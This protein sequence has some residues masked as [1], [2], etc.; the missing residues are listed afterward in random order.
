[1]QMGFSEQQARQ[2]LAQ[3]NGDFQAAIN[4]LLG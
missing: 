2:A 4:S 1:M 3:H